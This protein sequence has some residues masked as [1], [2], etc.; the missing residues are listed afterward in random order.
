MNRLEDSHNDN[1][2]A[3]PVAPLVRVEEIGSKP[4]LG[5]IVIVVTTLFF[6]GFLGYLFLFS[7]PD[8]RPV[9]ALSVIVPG[10]VAYGWVLRN[11]PRYNLVAMVGVFGLLAFVYLYFALQPFLNLRPLRVLFTIMAAPVLL[12]GAWSWF[13][14]RNG[15]E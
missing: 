12:G 8:R 11:C 9:M 6:C 10:L 13:K 5:P 1:P 15:S 4:V 2:Y 7:P 14:F 3:S